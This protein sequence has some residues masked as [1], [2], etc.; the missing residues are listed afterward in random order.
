MPNDRNEVSYY[1]EIQRYIEEQ[2]K[3]NFRLTRQRDLF[4][5]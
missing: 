3:S 2:L 5:Y 1:P 4:V